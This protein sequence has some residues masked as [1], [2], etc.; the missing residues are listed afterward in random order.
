VINVN[1]TNAM[2]VV[3][4]NSTVKVAQTVISLNGS[5]D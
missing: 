1:F 5:A 3:K 2:N 4:L